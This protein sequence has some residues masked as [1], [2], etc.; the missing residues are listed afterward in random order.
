[1]KPNEEQFP[2]YYD[3]ED[4][5]ECYEGDE[6]LML[7][8]IIFCVMGLIGIVSTIWWIIDVIVYLI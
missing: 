4:D 7:G 5:D 1:M 6:Y 2:S 3:I 8:I